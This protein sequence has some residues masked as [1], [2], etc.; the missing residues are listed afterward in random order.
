MNPMTTIAKTMRA[1]QITAYDG[2]PESLKMVELPVPTPKAGQVLVKMHAS[3]INPSDLLFLS[4]I[5][6]IKRPL[7]AIAGFEG[8]GTV[9]ANGGG[10]LGS[11]YMNKQVSLVGGDSNSTGAWAEYMIVPALTV[12]PIIKGI[13][14]DE[15]SMMFVNP[16]TAVM[17]MDKAKKQKHPGFV[18]TAAAGA[19]GQML[20]RM[21]NA[22]NMP[23][24][25]IVRRPSQ[26]EALR[27]LGARYVL[28]SSDEHFD[29]QLA[30]L[31]AQLKITLAFD[32]VAGE[33]PQKLLSLMPRRTKVIV[34]GALQE[35]VP[36]ITTHQ[37]VFE[38]K[39]IEGLWLADLAV[40]GINIPQLI[41]AT[42]KMR[43]VAKTMLKSHIQ[44]TYPIER[45]HEALARYR[46]HMSEGKV[47][48][49]FD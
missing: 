42:M 38:A 37:L 49:K 7:P 12:S 40:D 28:D 41:M 9:V 18:Q 31:S 11:F 19:L 21:A 34:Y 8:S 23:A 14:M 25:H 26:A 3:P 22:Q 20:V 33:M 45:T 36:T 30:S 47:L 44:A 24:I 35:G 10:L 39:K 27:Q 32:A 6:G 16:N 13:S 5:Y 2:K 4:G 29:Q 43:K 17:L 46:E 48:I 15:A 1:L